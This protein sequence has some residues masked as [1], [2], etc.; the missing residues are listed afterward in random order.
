MMTLRPIIDVPGYVPKKGLADLID[1]AQYYARGGIEYLMLARRYERADKEPRIRRAGPGRF[2][3]SISKQTSIHYYRCA[4]SDFAYAS[5]RFNSLANKSDNDDVKAQ[6]LHAA[7]RADSI[8]ARIGA[9]AQYMADA[10][11]S[12][13]YL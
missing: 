8:K 7:M 11:V 3:R 5:D 10:P 4:V 2:V 1:D 6:A 9:K 13:K 12:E